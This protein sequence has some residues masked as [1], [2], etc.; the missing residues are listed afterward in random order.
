MAAVVV[1]RALKLARVEM[2]KSCASAA[3]PTVRI[4]VAVSTSRSEKPPS[5]VHRDFAKT[6]HPDALGL[7]V[8]DKCDRHRLA[9]GRPGIHVRQVSVRGSIGPELDGSRR[10]D[11]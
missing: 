8:P 3:S 1:D 4:V 6:V 11:R 5:A 2:A 7:S 10:F 9:D